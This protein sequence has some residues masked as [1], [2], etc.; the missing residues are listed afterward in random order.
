MPASDNCPKVLIIGLDGADFGAVNGSIGAGRMPNLKRMREIGTYG[1]LRSTYPS[2][3]APAWS[4][5][6]TGLWPG[7]H[8]IFNFRSRPYPAG[9]PAGYSRPLMDSSALVGRTLWSALTANGLSVGAI[10]FPVTYPPEPVEGY[11]VC[12]MLAGGETEDFVYPAELAA[13]IRQRFPSYRVDMEHLLKEDFKS[14]HPAVY[15]E[16][17]KDEDEPGRGDSPYSEEDTERTE[18]R[19]RSLGYI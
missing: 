12:G 5:F 14:A 17:N 8:G 16:A 18:A 6:I 1:V 4:S 19:L 13:D 3:T 10:N 15:V 7:N 9:N 11:M 2:F